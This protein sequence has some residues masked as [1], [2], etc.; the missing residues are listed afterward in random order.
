MKRTIPTFLAV[1]M[2]FFFISGPLDSHAQKGVK[3]LVVEV[4]FSFD[5]GK[6]VSGIYLSYPDGK[7]EVIPLNGLVGKE[8]IEKNGAIIMKKFNQLYADGWILENSC[9]GDNSKR[10]LFRKE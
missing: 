10:Y 1:T 4:I 3:I 9:G 8:N 5:G 2:L 7:S 6:D